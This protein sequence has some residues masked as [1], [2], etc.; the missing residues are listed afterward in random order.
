MNSQKQSIF[1]LKNENLCNN[2][3]WLTTA[4]LIG[5][6]W[7]APDV[8]DADREAD[9]REQELPAVAPVAALGHRGERRPAD[10][11]VE[12]CAALEHGLASRHNVRREAPL[13]VSRMVSV[14]GAVPLTQRTA[15][16]YSG[17][18]GRGRRRWHRVAPPWGHKFKAF[19]NSCYNSLR[20]N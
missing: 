9:A 16:R 18:V 14:H 2:V 15:A 11:R 3:L 20:W 1:F 8:A 19:K 10:G 5:E 12:G 6:I 17:D 13:S 4:I 7:K